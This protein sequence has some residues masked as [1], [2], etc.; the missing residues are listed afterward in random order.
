MLL[1][2]AT[3]NMGYWSH[4]KVHDEAWGFLMDELAPDI[5][6][7]QE[8]R[9]PAGVDPSGMTWCPVKRRNGK[10]EQ[11]GTGIVTKGLPINCLLV[12]CSH[13]GGL[14]AAEVSIPDHPAVTVISMYGVLESVPHGQ[15]YAT[16]TVHRMLSDLTYLLMGE[17]EYAGKHKNV[18]LG[19]DLNIS[20]QCDEMWGGKQRYTHAHRICFDRIE[21]FGLTNCYA[22]FY[23]DYVQ[24]MRHSRSSLPWQDDYL[25]VSRNLAASLKSCVVL[26]EEY[27]E[28]IKGFS[29]HNPVVAGL[30]I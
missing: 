29:D 26:N 17:G 27:D 21:D 2:V 4:K 23:N 13:P 8:A 11:W 15:A 14:V 28:C 10:V 3:W 6:L 18:V 30:D 20:V 22:P 1:K 16:T 9:P 5:A 12:E 25:F 19:G 24:T 7:I